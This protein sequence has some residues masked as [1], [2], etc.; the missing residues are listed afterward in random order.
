MKHD[1]QRLLPARNFPGVFLK[2]FNVFFIPC[3]VLAGTAFILFIHSM[4]ADVRP[5][6]DTYETFYSLTYGLEGYQ[7]L[8]TAWKPRVFST[9]ASA[10]TVR[11]GLWLLNKTNVAFIRSPAEITVALW[12]AGWFVFCCL[13]LLLYFKQRAL[14]YIFG[15][16]AAISFGYLPRMEMAARYYPWDMTALSVFTLFMLFWIKR[17]YWLGVI[18]IVL[19]IGFKETVLI[20]AIAFLFA[21]LPWKMRIA[22]LI[23][24]LLGSSLVKIG[25]DASLGLPPFFTM[26]TRWN[27]DPQQ[28]LYVLSNLYSLKTI[29]PFFVNAGTL[30]ALLMVPNYNKNILVFKLLAICF[31]AG[32]FAFANIIEY[33]VWFE[34]IPFSIYALDLSIKQTEVVEHNA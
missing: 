6:T 21:E 34:M 2:V 16:F 29:L 15:F 11:V 1:S 4:S 25:I 8:K 5:N 30:L 9:G 26:E 17:Q 24:S 20:L 31:I 10:F 33:R 3:I 23:S 19:G 27:G 14:L 7:D 32:L 13:S 22:L 12:T 28:T 18:V